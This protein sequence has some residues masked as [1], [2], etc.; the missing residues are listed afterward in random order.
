MSLGIK[1]GFPG[2]EL[3]ELDLKDEEKCAGQRSEGKTSQDISHLLT[4]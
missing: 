3:R 1:E 2:E 4:S